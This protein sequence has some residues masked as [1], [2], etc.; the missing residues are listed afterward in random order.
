M[1]LL[2]FFIILP[3]GYFAYKG[4]VNGLIKE[5]LSIAGIVL[6]VFFTFAYMDSVS[7]IFEVFFDNP[8]YAI[9][10]AGIFLFIFTVATVQ[11][12]AYAARKFLEVIKINFINRIAGLLFGGVKSGIVIS[13]F[14]LL[15]AGFN[16]P[17]EQT[18]NESL[19]YSYVIYLAPAVFNM[20]AFIYPGVEDFISTIETTIEENNPI[21]NLPIFEKPEL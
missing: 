14:L 18:R 12:I 21:K 17:G 1:S 15:F 13:A 3:I 16:L 19:T 5:V 11:F 2:D 4:F 7:V 10:A 9:I 8:D 20:V 6:A